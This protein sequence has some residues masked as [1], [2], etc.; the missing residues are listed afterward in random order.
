MLSHCVLHKYGHYITLCYGSSSTSVRLLAGLPL[1]VQGLREAR[2]ELE[3]KK[4]GKQRGTEYKE[5]RERQ[6]VLYRWQCTHSLW[7]FQSCSLGLPS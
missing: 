6:N 3:N 2:V 5:V 4:K 7:Y 1:E